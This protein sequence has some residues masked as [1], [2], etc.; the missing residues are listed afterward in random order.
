MTIPSQ[1]RVI[2]TCVVSSAVR[3]GAPD[4]ERLLWAQ[5]TSLRREPGVVRKQL[6]WEAVGSG[7]SLAAGG[8]GTGLS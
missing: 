4:K 5:V 2:S 7:R 8:G 3:L 1:H 6:C